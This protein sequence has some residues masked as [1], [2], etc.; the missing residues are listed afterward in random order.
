MNAVIDWLEESKT[1]DRVSDTYD[2]YRP[3]YPD[4]LINKIIE[5]SAIDSSSKLLEI[6]AGSGKATELFVNRDLNI[7]CI[8]QG[9]NLAQ[10]GRDKFKEINQ[11]SYECVAF[12]DWE[13]HEKTYDLAFSA[14][15]FHWI[16]KPQGYKTLVKAL[17]QNGQMMIF[18]NKCVN[19]GDEVSVDL[20]KLLKE[21]KILNM[22][23]KKDMKTF[24][25]RTYD[26]IVTTDLFK[27]IEIFDYPWEREYSFNDFINFLSTTNGYISLESQKKYIFNERLRELFFEYNDKVIFNFNAVLFSARKS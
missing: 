12:Q 27:E 4:V 23:A 15:A 5:K 2:L 3:S 24:K 8:E 19:S 6:G 7:H 10:K 25:N 9:E 18:W 21:Y 22:L 1:F 14:Q 20:S 16:P 11:V 26:G 17:K 13:V